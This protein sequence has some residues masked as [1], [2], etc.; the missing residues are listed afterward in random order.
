[1][2]VPRSA[3]A[4]YSCRWPLTSCSNF[5]DCR[6]LSGEPYDARRPRRVVSAQSMRLIV[7]CLNC[8]KIFV[9]KHEAWRGTTQTEFW[10]VWCSGTI[11]TELT[12]AVHDGSASR[13][14]LWTLKQKSWVNEK[15]PILRPTQTL[16][17]AIFWWVIGFSTNNLIYCY[18]KCI[19]YRRSKT[20]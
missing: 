14:I 9:L 19:L 10:I 20:G 12:L 18:L 15:G 13:R 1:M 3:G 2:P 8:D 5:P 6:S 4:F 17:S 7:S 11:N 16:I